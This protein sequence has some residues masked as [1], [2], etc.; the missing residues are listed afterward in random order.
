MRTVDQLAKL[1]YTVPP[2]NQGQIV[3]VAYAV[4]AQAD[5]VVKRTADQSFAPGFPERV[6]FEVADVDEIEG[7]FEPWNQT[8]VVTEDCWDSAEYP[9]P[10]VAFAKRTPGPRVRYYQG[11]DFD[12]VQ[13]A[14]DEAAGNSKWTPD[15][16]SQLSLGQG[17][18]SVPL[19][20]RGAAE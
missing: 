12:A 13:E 1:T 7:D 18:Y 19:V 16:T 2:E 3:E 17:W 15:Y 11:T 20:K 4:D 10:E 14:V 9:K 8:P 6:V 5:L